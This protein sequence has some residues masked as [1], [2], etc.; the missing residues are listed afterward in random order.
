MPRL[1]Y[2]DGITIWINTRDHLPPHFHARYSGDEVRIE[3]ANMTVMTG[4]LPSTK[5]RVLLRWANAHK[6]ELMRNWNLAQ[7]GWPHKPIA[8]TLPKEG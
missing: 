3:L 8:P 6:S 2:L 7:A 4:R 5:M 1:C